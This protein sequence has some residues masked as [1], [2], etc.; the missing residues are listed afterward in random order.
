M[1]RVPEELSP[2]MLQAAPERTPGR[3]AAELEF[4]EVRVN[5]HKRKQCRNKFCWQTMKAAQSYCFHKRHAGVNIQPYRC[6]HCGGIHVG[7]FRPDDLP[8]LETTMSKTR[9]YQIWP[10]RDGFPLDRT[11]TN[12]A[13]AEER[14]RDYHTARLMESD[15]DEE[16]FAELCL[17]DMQAQA[18]F[19]QERRV[20][21]DH[22]VRQ[23]AAW[24]AEKRKWADCSSR[25]APPKVSAR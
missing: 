20:D 22:A 25:P 23:R 14:L 16:E 4:P 21:P 8:E 12:R 10:G 9:V 2:R 3:S 13:E 17:R 7:H 11:F 6:P 1:Y 5:R 19:E 18:D 15:L 24:H